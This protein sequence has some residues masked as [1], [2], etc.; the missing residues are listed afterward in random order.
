M[1]QPAKRSSLEGTTLSLLFKARNGDASAIGAICERYLPRLRRWAQGRI[2]AW[3]RN[4]VDTEDIV[5]D[6][7]MKTMARIETFDPH[8]SASLQAYIHTALRNRITDLVREARQQREVLP[9]EERREDPAA[10]PLAEAIGRERFARYTGAL[11]RL[12]EEDRGLIIMRFE[13]GF[14]H[15]EIARETGRATPDGARMALRRALV[16]LGEEMSRE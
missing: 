12:G 5:Q 9:V 11:Q 7:L 4:G 2:P 6:A 3:A 1:P 8:H 13:W 16:R 14:S 15:Q 10:D